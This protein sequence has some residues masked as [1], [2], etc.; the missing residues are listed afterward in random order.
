VTKVCHNWKIVYPILLWHIFNVICYSNFWKL[1]VS[2]QG[3]SLLKKEIFLVGSNMGNFLKF[4]NES[5][6]TPKKSLEL[7]SARSRFECIV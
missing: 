2:D 3:L 6:I 5:K 7:Y 4:R 1:M